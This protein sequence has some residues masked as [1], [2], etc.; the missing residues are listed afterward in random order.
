[1]TTDE[2]LENLEREL[3]A[4]RAELAERVRTRAV[5]VVGENGNV[6][7]ILRVDPDGPG[8]VRRGGQDALASP[9]TD[10]CCPDARNEVI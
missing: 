2:R 7:A 9:V 8:P 6:R 3:A 4:L 5:E 10:A 1:M